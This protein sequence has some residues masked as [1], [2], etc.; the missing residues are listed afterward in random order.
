MEMRS[1]STRNRSQQAVAIKVDHHKFRRP[2]GRFG[3]DERRPLPG[4]IAGTPGKQRPVRGDG[5]DFRLSIR[6]RIRGGDRHKRC[7]A[8]VVEARGTARSAMCDRSARRRAAV[9]R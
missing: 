4:S 7:V 3:V 1:G 6:V 2:G 9:R 5:V 8:Q